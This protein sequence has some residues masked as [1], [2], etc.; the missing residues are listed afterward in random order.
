MP[1]ERKTYS[2]NVQM[3]LSIIPIVDL[4]AAYRIEK[5]RLWVLF[6][7]GMMLI[8]GALMVLGD[9][10]IEFIIGM[11]I[12]IPI[13]LFLMRHFTMEW[14]NEINTSKSHDSSLS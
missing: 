4:W 8:S 9:P 5:L 1:V 7:I 11:A 10:T 14:N 2:V 12:T 13:A 6:W 3:I